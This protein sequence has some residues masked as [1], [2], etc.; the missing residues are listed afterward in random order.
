MIV[1]QKG[2][3]I[4][5]TELSDGEWTL[6]KVLW[7]S[8]PSTIIQLTG[9]MRDRTGWSKHTI[10]SMLSRLENKGAVRYQSNGRAKVYSPVLQR[11]DAVKRETSRFLDKVFDGRLGVMLNAV[12]DSRPLTQEDLEEL[13]AVLEK[14]KEEENHD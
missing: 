4:L 3:A 9:A 10:I 1:Y 7:D 12:M 2:E 6:M 13:S 5:K 11:E 8:A 14:A